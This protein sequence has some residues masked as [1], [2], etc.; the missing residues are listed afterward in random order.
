MHQVGSIYKTVQG[1]TVNKTLNYSS[2]LRIL[3]AIA[4]KSHRTNSFRCFDRETAFLWNCSTFI[5]NQL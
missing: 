2:G 5:N 1:C 3:C 4:A